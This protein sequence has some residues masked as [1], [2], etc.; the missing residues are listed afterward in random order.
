MNDADIDQLKQSY[1]NG[2]H[3]IVVLLYFLV[4]L[5]V[6]IA[7]LYVVSKLVAS[8]PLKAA[9][10]FDPEK[11]RKNQDSADPAGDTED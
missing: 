7:V 9:K 6:V 10:P 4:G 3:D 5:L 1:A 2:F 11:E 8:I